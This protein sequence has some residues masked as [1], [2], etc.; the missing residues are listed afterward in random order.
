MG[1]DLPKV[2][3]VSP[4]PVRV[5]EMCF[6]VLRDVGDASPK[7]REPTCAGAA[8]LQLLWHELI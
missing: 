4:P 3:L 8:A 1:Q 5:T 7:H 2:W 6:G